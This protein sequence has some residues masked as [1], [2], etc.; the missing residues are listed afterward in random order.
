MSEIDRALKI[1]EAG[2]DQFGRETRPEL[3]IQ[4][5]KDGRLSEERIDI[6]IKRLLRQKFQLGLFDNPFV[7]ELKV[8]EIVGNKNLFS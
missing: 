3:V 7:D 5:V 2:C 1:L 6:S 8:N 4:L